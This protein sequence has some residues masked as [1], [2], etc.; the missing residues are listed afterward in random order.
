MYTSTLAF[1][2]AFIP[3]KLQNNRRTLVS[4]LIFAVG[5]IVGW[6]FALALAFPFIFE[7]LFIHGADSVA[8]ETKMSWIVQ[9]WKRLFAAGLSALLIFV[10][11]QS[12]SFH[13]V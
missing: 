5:G 13:R 4:T 8:P 12:L 10:R 11:F 9:R 3:S 2:Y 6:P 7:E 1:S